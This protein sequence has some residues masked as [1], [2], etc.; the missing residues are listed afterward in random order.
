MKPT[1]IIITCEHGGNRVP[2]RYRTLFRDRQR[3]LA[4]HAGYDRGALQIAR[5]LRRQAGGVP[6]F[7][8][9][10]TRLLVDLNRSMPGNLF[11]AVTR[12]LPVHEQE[13]VLESHYRPYRTAV[14]KAIAAAISSGHRVLHIGVHTFT[15]VRNGVRRR[16]GI[17]VLFDPARA[18]ETR[19]SRRWA[20]ALKTHLP[21]HRVRLNYPYRGTDDGFTTTLRTTFA[22]GDY[23][24][25]ELEVNRRLADRDPARVR[26]LAAKLHMALQVALES[27]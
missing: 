16:A 14:E 8:A 10:T 2:S 9:T 27:S 6:L 22:D 23:A 21:R 24:G 11:S 19:F 4:S 3:L 15:P 18:W 17:G 12:E 5:L 13:R 7:Y 25:I 1:S 20:A 26:L